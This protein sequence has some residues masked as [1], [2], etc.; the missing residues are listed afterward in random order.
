M[1][2][3]AIA[4]TRPKWVAITVMTARRYLMASSG[5]ANWAL[6]GR[7]TSVVTAATAAGR[8]RRA[9]RCMRKI[10]SKG[11][12]GRPRLPGGAR[13]VYAP[14]RAPPLE[15]RQ[16]GG[17]RAAT[18]YSAP[19]RAAGIVAHRTTRAR[20]HGR[21]RDRSGAGLGSPDPRVPLAARVLRGLDAHRRLARRQRD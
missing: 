5:F 6:A 8:T 20:T 9:T 13:R 15:P 11:W 21:R 3:F 14:A 16:A 2:P 19:C 17:R 10:S 12:Q 1:R 4:A 7:A 18:L